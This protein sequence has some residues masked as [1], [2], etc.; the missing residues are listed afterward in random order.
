MRNEVL[1]LALGATLTLTA[2]GGGG[3]RQ[4]SAPPQA[5]APAA[6]APATAAGGAAEFG[7]PECD[8]Y[9]AKYMACVDTKVPEAVRATVRQQLDQTKAQWKQ[10]AAAPG[11]KEGLAM[12]CKAASDAARTSMAAYGCQ[13]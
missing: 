10:A 9:I 12:G 8:D 2:C 6:T 4:E 11:G 1:S 3:S 13:F 5:Q 7:V